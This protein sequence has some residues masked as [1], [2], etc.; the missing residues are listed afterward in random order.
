MARR[1][2]PEHILNF[3]PSNMQH[4]RSIG[5]LAL[6]FILRHLATE[7]CT[8]TRNPYLSFSRPTAIFV[9][10]G[11]TFAYSDSAVPGGQNALECS[12]MHCLKM[13]FVHPGTAEWPRYPLRLA[14]CPQKF[15]SHFPFHGICRGLAQLK[16]P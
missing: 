9:S 15:I 7:Y 13:H 11:R 1:I 3:H 4:T 10:W 14:L 8:L 16:W 2:L 12:E 6:S 5:P